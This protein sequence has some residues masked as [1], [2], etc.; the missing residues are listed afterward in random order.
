MNLGGSFEPQVQMTGGGGSFIWGGGSFIWGGGSFRTFTPVRG[1]RS[2]SSLSIHTL[3]YWASHLPSPI[4]SIL[5][6]LH[7]YKIPSC[8]G[9]CMV[10]G[11]SE[12]Y[13]SMHTNTHGNFFIFH[14]HASI[15]GTH[16]QMCAEKGYKSRRNV[17]DDHS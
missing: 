16:E 5:S 17:S 9:G 4:R 7:T 3:H 14:K 13:L 6:V 12:V 15:Q 1:R 10:Y 8:S 11:W 2:T